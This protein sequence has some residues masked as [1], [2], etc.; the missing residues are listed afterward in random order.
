[1]SISLKKNETLNLSKDARSG[2]NNVRMGL[3][4]DAMEKKGMFGKKI[5]LII[6]F[7]FLKLILN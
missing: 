7:L 6:W 3:G 5:T 2:L 4:W 1:M